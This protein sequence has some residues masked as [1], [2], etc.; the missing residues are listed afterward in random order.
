MKFVVDNWYFLV[1]IVAVI[2]VAA[3]YIRNFLNKPTEQQVQKVKEWLLYA[4][5]EAQQILGGGTGQLK[6]RYV[7]DKFVSTFPAI[8][9]KISFESFSNLVDLVLVKF[10]HLLSTNVNI[11]NLIN[12]QGEI[13]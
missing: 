7:Y 5:A 13:L 9:E 3:A 8:A 11:Q 12:Q 4:V 10:N 6:L 1:L 2:V